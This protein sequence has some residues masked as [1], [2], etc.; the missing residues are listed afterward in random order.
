M[1]MAQVQPYW[2]FIIMALNG[3]IAGWIAGSLLG[4]AGGLIRNLIVGIIG[5]FVGGW[6]VHAGLLKLPFT[7]GIPFGDQVVVSTIG[8]L[9][10]MIIARIVAR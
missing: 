3:M 7:T 2:P 9:L 6:L 8:A 4:G 5:A 1:T 10:V